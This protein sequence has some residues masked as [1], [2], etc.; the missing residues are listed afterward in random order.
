MLPALKLSQ[1]FFFLT[2]IRWL[3]K[4]IPNF[5]KCSPQP[6]RLSEALF[7][8]K[9]F[10]LSSVRAHFLKWKTPKAS[11]ASVKV[12][13]VVFLST[14][15]APWVGD[16]DGSTRACFFQQPRAQIMKTQENRKCTK[17]TKSRRQ[18]SFQWVWH[19]TEKQS[20]VE[21]GLMFPK[22]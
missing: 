22:S 8:A 13:P 15:E 10:H 14:E 2:D 7:N 4:T 5:G 9:L 20:E 18:S 17:A 12:P 16:E 1:S 19:R 3:M 6:K 11:K 21:A